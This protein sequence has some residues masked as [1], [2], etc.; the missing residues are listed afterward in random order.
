MCNGEV[1][2][3]GRHVKFDSTWIQS[4]SLDFGNRNKTTQFVQRPAAIKIHNELLPESLQSGAMLQELN[5]ESLASCHKADALVGDC[6][7]KSTMDW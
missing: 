2:N 7:I 4:D 3:L 6:S 5:C 1:V